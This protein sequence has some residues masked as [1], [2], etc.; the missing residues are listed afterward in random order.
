MDYLLHAATCVEFGPAGLLTQAPLDTN[1]INKLPRDVTRTEPCRNHIIVFGVRAQHHLFFS[2][3]P[4][5]R[6]LANMDG[7]TPTSPARTHLSRTACERCRRQKV[8][9]ASAKLALSNHT[10]SC[11]QLRCSREQPVCLRCNRSSASCHYPQL[12]DRRA[13]AARREASRAVQAEQAEQAA[14]PAITYYVNGSTDQSG[15]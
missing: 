9:S 13:L 10:Y 5:P 15:M 3:V 6:D 4:L 8:Q 11:L 2:P 14:R 1:E 12:A 7:A